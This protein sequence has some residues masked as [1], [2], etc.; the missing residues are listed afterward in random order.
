MSLVLVSNSI[1]ANRRDGADQLDDSVPRR[2]YIEIAQRLG[3]E[4]VGYDLFDTFW[5]RWFRQVEK[6]LKLD[7]VESL[8]AATQSSKHDLVLS[9]SEKIAIPLACLLAVAGRRMPHIVIAHKLSSGLK[10][11]LLRVWPIYRNFSSLICVCQSQADYA[12]RQLG[13]PRSKVN[14]VYHE[15]DHHF[16]RPFK[17]DAEDY[18]LAVGQE[19]RDY[20]TLL[21]AI[22]GTGLRTVVVASSPWSTSQIRLDEAGAVTVLSNITYQDLRMLYARARLVVV[23]L[24]DV[25][26]AA[27]VTAVLEAMAMAKPLIVSRAR[28]IVDYVVHNETGMYVA[29]GDPL[30]LR[31]AISSLW[32]RTEE[33]N[34]LGTNARQAVEEC[35]NLDAYV[36]RVTEIARQTTAP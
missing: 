35:M 14:F 34:R 28:G 15:V 22:A 27:G 23:P 36:N 8:F 31:E 19:Q 21:Q 18:I 32:G 2:D 3:G 20:P 13:M 25:D 33:V 26:Y 30:E 9:T 11:F 10:A 4:L 1:K 17:L 6:R 7:L 5:Y 16:Y 12:V 29:P 24:L